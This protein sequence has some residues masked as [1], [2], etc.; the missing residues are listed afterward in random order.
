MYYH[1]NDFLSDWGYEAAGTKKLFAAI[2]PEK[3]NTRV[4]PEGRDMGTLAW[5]IMITLKEMME[6]TGLKITG[7][8]NQD[9]DEQSGPEELLN[10]YTK[11]SD[12]LV[13]QVKN[14]TDVDLQVS[15][16]MYG[17]S[18]KR[19]VT[20]DILIKHQAHHRGQL[21]VLMRQAG[22]PVAGMYGPS[23]EEWKAMNMEPQ[24]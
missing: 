11:S 5:H 9:W 21:T 18:W 22:L 20:L 14:W 15:D 4:Y 19:G 2:T 1:I 24:K 16:N 3:L 6:H 23:K 8:A 7:P 17:E 12:S 13:E 10:W